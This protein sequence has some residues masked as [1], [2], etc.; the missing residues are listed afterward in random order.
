MALVNYDSQALPAMTWEQLE[1]VLRDEAATP[2]QQ[3]MVH[4]LVVGLCNQ[5][6][7]LTLGG[8]VREIAI[9]TLAVTDQLGGERIM[10]SS[11]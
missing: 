3:A 9:I 6:R 8:V 11:P 4:H 5:S 7:F 1:I 2:L 10:S